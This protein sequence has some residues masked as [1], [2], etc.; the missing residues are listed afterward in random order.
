MS[1]KIAGD[2][3]VP[4]WLLLANDALPLSL[5][6]TNNFEVALQ[7][8]RKISLALTVSV[9]LNL[10]YFI[11]NIMVSAMMVSEENRQPKD[12]IEFHC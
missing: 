12:S 6:V 11:G 8:V 4:S 9:C 5:S 3:K 2:L 7:D 1:D 10:L